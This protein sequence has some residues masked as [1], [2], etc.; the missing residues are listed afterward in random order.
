MKSL[1]RL[2]ALLALALAGI[3]HGQEPHA[4][5][6][7]GMPQLLI[8]VSEKLLN[9]SVRQKIDRTEPFQELILDSQVTGMRRTIASVRAELSPDPDRG[10]VWIITQGKACARGLGR[11]DH[12]LTTTDAIIHFEVG[13][14]IAIDG[15]RISRK[16]GPLSAEAEVALL[17]AT[18]LNGD[19]DTLMAQMAPLGFKRQKRIIEGYTAGITARR[20]AERF[21][22][23]LN[24]MLATLAQNLEQA[25]T[26]AKSQGLAT[27]SL[28][29]STV[30][31]RLQARLRFAAEDKKSPGLAPRL[32][33][34]LDLGVRIHESLVNQAARGSLGGKTL[35]I[36]E[37]ASLWRQL[38]KPLFKG[39]DGSNQLDKLL[40][41]LQKGMPGNKVTVSFADH[42]PVVVR[43]AP[44]GLNLEVHVRQFTLADI[45]LGGIRAKVNYRLEKIKSNFSLVRQGPIELRASDDKN[46]GK[47]P[48][49]LG[50]PLRGIV[51]AMAE[52]IFLP[53]FGLVDLTP[54]AP[55]SG[56]GLLSP[57]AAQIQPGWL[58]LGWK[59]PADR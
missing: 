18:G 8:D 17:G 42:D 25:L 46:P 27:E 28:S 15:Q 51:V 1:G 44:E 4:K 57:M 56:I 5:P 52:S 26:V 12:L 47:K 49:A 30:P 50:E 32:P 7:S 34:Q 53:R 24:P 54:P 22:E 35:A 29:F 9:A 6:A 19:P 41:Q 14:L 11:Q 31:P 58:V 38:T 20:V 55:L 3:S 2:A 48:A 37:V 33:D 36:D 23:E 43:F 16:R 45:P 10:M 40:A 59:L 21:E 13:Q 39:Q